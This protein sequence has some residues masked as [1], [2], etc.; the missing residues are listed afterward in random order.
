M[1]GM[2]DA[3]WNRIQEKRARNAY[4]RGLDE[5]ARKAQAPAKPKA[6]RARAPRPSRATGVGRGGRE[7]IYTHCKGCGRPLRPRQKTATDMPGTRMHYRGGYCK[8]CTNPRKGM[9]GR[10]QKRSRV[11]RVCQRGMRM[12]SRESLADR[13]GTVPYGRDDM[14]RTCA[15]KEAINKS[16][17]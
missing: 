11:C 9:L 6:P 3:T 15:K 8:P 1:D 4:F 13:P 12:S 14:C 7:Q 10:P 2:D 5:A 16:H 17:Q